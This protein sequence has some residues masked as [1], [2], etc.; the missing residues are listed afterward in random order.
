MRKVLT[1]VARAGGFVVL[2]ATAFAV[3]VAFQGPQGLIR[4]ALTR[5][6]TYPPQRALDAFARSQWQEAFKEATSCTEWTS[7]YGAKLQRQLEVERS[8]MPNEK[9]GDYMEVSNVMRR[10]SLNS[11]AHCSLIAAESAEQLG[12]PMEAA[13]WLEATRRL[14]Y[15][16]VWDSSSKRFW[17]PAARAE[18]QIALHAADAR[19]RQ[20]PH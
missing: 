15:A 17:S 9:P 14:T 8:P 16:R 2:L 1:L 12:Q 7:S 3:V 20:A 18:E 5:S 11:F 4:Q 6:F 10:G 19:R 13:K